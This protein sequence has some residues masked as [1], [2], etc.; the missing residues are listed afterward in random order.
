VSIVIVIGS[1]VGN[2]GTGVVL[3]CLLL[4]YS[5]FLLRVTYVR[6]RASAD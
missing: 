6:R 5:V 3:G 1:A 4:V 2:Y